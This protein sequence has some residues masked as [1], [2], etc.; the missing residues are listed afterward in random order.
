LEALSKNC[1]PA[2]PF[3]KLLARKPFQ[4]RLER[5]RRSGVIKNT[6]KDKTYRKEVLIRI[7]PINFQEVI[8]QAKVQT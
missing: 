1:L 3:K 6:N 5:K 7:R 2:S 8:S 4:K